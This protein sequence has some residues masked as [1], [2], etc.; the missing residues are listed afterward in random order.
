MTVW[1]MNITLQHYLEGIYAYHL[2]VYSVTKSGSNTIYTHQTT[3]NY[4]LVL[5]CGSML[6]SVGPSQKLLFI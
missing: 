3:W 1:Y 2:L 6:G 4:A 5:T